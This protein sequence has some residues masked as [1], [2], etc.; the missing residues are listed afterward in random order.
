MATARDLTERDAMEEQQRR[1]RLLF[2]LVIENTSEGV[3]V[4]DNEMRYLVW[5]AAMERFNGQSRDDVLGKTVFET[6]PGFAEHSVGDGWREA[7][8]GRPSEMRDYRFFSRF[9]GAEVVYDADFTPLYGQ[10]GAIIGA[11]CILHDTTERQR[12]E[13]LSRLETV[14]QLTGGVAHDFNNLLTA[15]M[16]SLEMIARNPSHERTESLAELALRSIQRGAQLTQQL[17]AFSRGQALHSVVADLNTLLAEIEVLIRRAVG[18][19]IEVIIDAAPALPPCKVDPAQFEAT[20][21]NLVMNARDAMSGGGRVMLTTRKVQGGDV[22][23]S[24]PL[25]PGD[26]VALVVSDNGEGM[27][28]AVAARAFEPFYTTKEVGKGTGLGLST[29]Y[30]FAKQSGGGVALISSPGNGTT[31][32]LYLPVTSKA[33]E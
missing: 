19:T 25:A 22:S 15:A 1:E 5:N 23:S 10:D 6:V 16:G 29:V 21:M 3:I 18:E 24:E 14:A 7:L 27:S 31:V 11:V 13:R 20:V 28:D 26:Y 9:R 33:V 12:M 4:V 30:G 2:E 32:T 17:L 8:S